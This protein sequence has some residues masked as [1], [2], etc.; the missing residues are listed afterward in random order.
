MSN[1]GHSPVEEVATEVAGPRPVVRAI[2]SNYVLHPNLAITIAARTR[3][4]ENQPRDVIHAFCSF[5]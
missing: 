1:M 5:R 4:L 3:R 2:F